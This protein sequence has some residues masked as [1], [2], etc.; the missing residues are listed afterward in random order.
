MIQSSDTPAAIPPPTPDVVVDV[1]GDV[2]CRPFQMAVLHRWWGV[3]V[4]W[5][6]K[7][8]HAWQSI[9]AVGG[10]FET[11]DVGR[12]DE[13]ANTATLRCLSDGAA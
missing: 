6:E 4:L 7:P 10:S 1:P 8:H 9:A 13:I 12:T 3:E 11:H 5:R 2:T